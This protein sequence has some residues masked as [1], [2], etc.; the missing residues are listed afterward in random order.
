MSNLTTEEEFHTLHKTLCLSFTTNKTKDV[1]WRK[2]QLKQLFWLLDENEDALVAAMSDDLHRHAFESLSYDV[3]DVKN[4]ILTMLKNI[5]GW[6]QGIPPPDAGFIFRYIGGAWIRKEPRGL[7]LVIGAWNYPLSTLFS[8]GAAAIAA[9]NCVIFKPSEMAP[10]TESLLAEL[11]PKYL[12]PATIALV[13]AGPPAMGKILEYRFDFIFYTGSTRVG[14][15]IAAAAAKHVTPTALELGGQAPAIIGKTADLDVSAKRLIAAKLTNLGQICVCVNH[16]FADPEVHDALVARLV[17]WMDYFCKEG[18]GLSGL[19]RMVSERNFDR[20]KDLLDRTEGKR[21]FDGPHVRADRL[22]HPTIVTDVT[23]TDS[24][25]SEELFGPVL[26]V[27]K[28]SVPEVLDYLRHSPS[29]LGLYIFSNDSAEIN[30]ILDS[31]NSGGVTINDVAIHPDVPSAPFGG[32]GDSGYGAYHGK[33]GFDT[34]SHNRTVVRL[35]GWVDYFLQWRYPPFD[36]KNRSETDAPR[37]T[38]KKGESL[39]DQSTSG[40]GCSVM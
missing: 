6:S 8:V 31:T 13:R 25:L 38:F 14:R 40:V 32:V 36:V 9:G 3:S 5:D 22:I 24:L 20:L 33:W 11:V 23:M 18:E 39:H 10:R 30:T 21:V 2:W 29:P 37:P 7:V 15:I 16:V 27:V 28:M 34:F 35:P 19:A 26:P 4:T 1:R 12:D 17:H